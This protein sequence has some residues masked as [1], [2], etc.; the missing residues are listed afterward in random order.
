MCSNLVKCTSIK[1]SENI[2]IITHSLGNVFVKRYTIVQYKK[3]NIAC[4][5]RL[6][7]QYCL[8]HSLI[9][10]QRVSPSFRLRIFF[11]NYLNLCFL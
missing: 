6:S 11:I 1:P 7:H 5:I 10:A 2:I 3:D 8:S 9:Y 4:I